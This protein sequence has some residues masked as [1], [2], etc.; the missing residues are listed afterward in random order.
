MSGNIWIF[1][2]NKTKKNNFY[3]CAKPF[4]L[5]V[6]YNLD[7]ILVK[8]SEKINC[9]ENNYKYFICNS[10]YHQDDMTSLYIGFPQMT[11]YMKSYDNETKLIYLFINDEFL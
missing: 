10:E 11:A 7:Y 5:D 3:D 2:D 1:G 8:V 6:F 9:F 4:N